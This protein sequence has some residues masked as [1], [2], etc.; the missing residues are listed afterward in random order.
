[1]G[2]LVYEVGQDGN[3]KLI[4]DLDEKDKSILVARGGPGG[5]GNM[6]FKSSVMRAPRIAEPGGEGEAKRLFFRA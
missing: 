4:A 5:R 1:M 2:T 3:R 6:H